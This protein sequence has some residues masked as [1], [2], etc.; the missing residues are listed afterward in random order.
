MNPI[1]VPL[2]SFDSICKDYNDPNNFVRLLHIL[3]PNPIPFGLSF[4]ELFNVKYSY[5]IKFKLKINNITFN[6][7][8]LIQNL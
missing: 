8:C 6:F 2:F 3:S 7:I 1:D 5:P 4:S